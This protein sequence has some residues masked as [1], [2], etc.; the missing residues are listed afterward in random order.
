MSFLYLLQMSKVLNLNM[1][2]RLTTCSR[3]RN[4]ILGLS[5][6]LLPYIVNVMSCCAGE[7]ICMPRL[8]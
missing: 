7:S 4:L 6:H 2:T 3:A 5:S 8:I 1:H